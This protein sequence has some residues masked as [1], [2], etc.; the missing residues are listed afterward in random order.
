LIADEPTAEVDADTESRLVAHF[1]ER[2]RNG[3]TTLLATHSQALAARTDR[4]VRLRDGRIV[5]V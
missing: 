2:R 5:D 1:D 3:L 4:V